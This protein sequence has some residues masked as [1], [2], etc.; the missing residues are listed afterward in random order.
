MGGAPYRVEVLPSAVKDTRRF[1]QSTLRRIYRHLVTLGENPFP[2]G[3]KKLQEHEQYYRIR[4][5]QYRIIYEV[6][7]E[8]RVVS[9]VRIAHRSTA[10]R[11]F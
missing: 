7:R 9:I 3:V 11:Q 4:V 5:G 8:V 10:Y 2:A 6:R 1:P